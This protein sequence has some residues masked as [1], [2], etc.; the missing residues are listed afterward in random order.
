MNLDLY[1]CQVW[2]AWKSFHCIL[3]ILLGSLVVGLHLWSCVFAMLLHPGAKAL[4]QTHDAR[5]RLTCLCPPRHYLPG[6][7]HLPVLDLRPRQSGLLLVSL[8]PWGTLQGSLLGWP[9]GLQSF[10]SLLWMKIIC[11]S[12]FSARL[13]L[14]VAY[15]I[16]IL[17][18]TIK[19]IS[20]ADLPDQCSN[21]RELSH[22]SRNM[23]DDNDYGCCDCVGQD[24]RDTGN[25]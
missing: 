19:A 7:S 17:H 4:P 15:T 18:C 25:K 9:K 2:G 24:C 10:R 22:E 14:K 11:Q 6:S 8:W 16:Y 21:Y 13:H 1:V 12:I 20:N 3:F 23:H 5:H